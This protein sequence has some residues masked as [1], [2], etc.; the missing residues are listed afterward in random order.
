[1]EIRLKNQIC[2][3]AM[4]I[5]GEFDHKKK[6]SSR[7]ERCAKF[8]HNHLTQVFQEMSPTKPSVIKATKLEDGNSPRISETNVRISSAWENSETFYRENNKNYKI[9]SMVS[10]PTTLPPQQTTRKFFLR[11]QI[12]ENL[13][14][15]SPEKSW[16]QVTY[17]GPGKVTIQ[18]VR[19]LVELI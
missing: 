7:D 15:S 16:C 11:T 18:Q 13:C 5:C 1:M 12:L 14:S 6:Y 2:R 3:S 17:S 8:V 19:R 4:E 9:G 10:Y